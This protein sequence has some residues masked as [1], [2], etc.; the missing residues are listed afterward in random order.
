MIYQRQTKL[1]LIILG[2]VLGAGVVVG[3]VCLP[4]IS[5]VSQTQ[6]Q[7]GETKVKLQV[8]A[9]EI[10]NYQKLAFNL[11]KVSAVKQRLLEIFPPRENSVSLVEGLEGAA[12][13]SGL[14]IS[15]LTITDNQTKNETSTGQVEKPLPQLVTGLGLVE[16]IPYTLQITGDYRGLVDFFSYLEHLPFIT[17]PNKLTVAA[18]QTQTDRAALLQNTGEAAAKLDGMLYI[19]KQ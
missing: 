6:K 16:E 3:L 1:V 11:S 5:K 14:T 10:E 7:I 9:A 18:D 12:A 8:I 17:I 19:F 4:L 15:K 13:V 2:I